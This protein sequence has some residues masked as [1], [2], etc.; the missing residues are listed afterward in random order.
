[1]I[2]RGAERGLAWAIPLGVALRRQWWHTFRPITMGVRALVIQ[3]DEILLVRGHGRTKWHM[4]G[5]GVKRGELLSATAQRE[6]GEETGWTIRVERL[7]GMYTNFGE[8][9]SD[10]IAIFVCTVLAQNRF[11]FN[12]E[13]A[14]ARFFPLGAL[15]PCHSAVHRRLADYATGAWGLYGSW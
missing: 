10:H 6:V 13:I 14:E 3:N 11:P 4:P 5:G 2:R 12:I 1:M 15:P 7:L 8:G 9:K